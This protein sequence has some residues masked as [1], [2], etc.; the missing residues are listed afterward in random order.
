GGGPTLVECKTYRMKGHA[1]HDG[2]SYVDPTELAQWRG[3]DPIA[4]FES[5]LQETGVMPAERR[6]ELVRE[7]H[8][9]LDAELAWGEEAPLPAPSDVFDGVYADPR[10]AERSRDGVFVG[11]GGAVVEQVERVEN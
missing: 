5:V 9:F 8:A 6:R 7:L 2:Q 10:I 11:A 3:R 1:E 4:R